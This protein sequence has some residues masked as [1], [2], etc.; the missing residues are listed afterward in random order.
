MK[1]RW[2]STGFWYGLKIWF[3]GGWYWFPDLGCWILY[4]R[5][6]RFVNPGIPHTGDDFHYYA[7]DDV[8]ETF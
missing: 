7:E 5:F 1:T 3:T 8:D 6:W 2:H 4:R